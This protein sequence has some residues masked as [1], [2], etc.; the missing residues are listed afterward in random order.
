MATNRPTIPDV[1][2]QFAFDLFQHRPKMRAPQ[3]QASK[4]YSTYAHAVGENS[5]S[6]LFVADTLVGVVKVRHFVGLFNE[7]A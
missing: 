3:I 1:W 5:L 2:P 6:L 7:E 4:T